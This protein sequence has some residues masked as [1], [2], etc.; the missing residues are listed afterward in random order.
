MT[1]NI[2]SAGTDAVLGAT[3]DGDGVNFAVFSENATRIELCLFS[4]AGEETRLVLPERTGS[5]FHGRI[6]GLRPGQLYGYRAHGP[7]E[8][9]E[10]HR[11]NPNKLLVDPYAKRI[12]GHPE[13]NDALHGYTVGAADEDLSFDERDSAP[14]MPR[15]VVE[16]PAFSWGDDERPATRLRDTVIYEAHVKGLTQ[17]HPEITQPGTFVGLASDPILEHLHRLG[18]SAVELLPSHAFLTD[19]F[20]QEKGLVNY[21][22]YQTIGF[23]A[24]HWDYLT[25]NGIADFQHMVAR[26]HAAGIEVLMDVVYNHTGEGSEL[27]PTLSFRGLDNASYYRLTPD[28]R[29]CIN[30]TGTGN[31]INMD[32][33]MVVRMIM[34]SLRYWVETFRVDGFRFDLGATLGRLSTG[35]DRDAPFLQACR[36]DPVLSKVKLIME[37]WDIGPGGYQVGGFPH[38]FL[39]WN[40]KF[41]DDV[42][43]FWRGDAGYAAALGQRI[44]GSAQQFDHSGRSATTSVNFLTAHDGFNLEDVVSYEH[45]HNEANG[46]DGRDGHSHNFSANYGVE[47][48]TDDPNVLEVRARKKR[49]MMA[50]LMLAQGTPMILAG[51]EL[52]HT[53]RG[54][55][56]VYNQDNETAW[57]DWED[58]DDVFLDFTSAM[59]RLRREHPILRQ[60]LWLHARERL[61]DGVEDLF[62][63]RANGEPMRSEDW[64]DANRRIVC[65]EMRTARGTPAY[66]AR[67][68]AIF[69]VFNAGGNRDVSLP[70]VPE[71][72]WWELEVDTA[73]PG[74]SG[75]PVRKK[76]IRVSG[77]SVAVFR[78]R[79]PERRE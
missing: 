19:N 1:L 78:L 6:D 69:A 45:R 68:Y 40:D 8:P 74:R 13:W 75:Q 30:D 27:G 65:V 11:F 36:Q 54:N 51:D 17:R 32:H 50:T 56:N 77:D 21:W 2:P 58:V 70:D 41:R 31:T 52:G 72:A 59:I 71:G 23:F 57:V 14:F 42:R 43:R 61:I 47:G 24:P 9:M 63:W 22:G 35:F 46:E 16:D 20:L 3:F 26:F 49:N 25:P 53:Q 4:E 55:N 66:D 18:I 5:V 48:P 38:P 73:R 34:D 39:E 79:E 10:G 15:C 28:K 62:W 29:H 64:N 37:P 33:P 44:T 12:T 76:R 7:Y 67:E 60:K